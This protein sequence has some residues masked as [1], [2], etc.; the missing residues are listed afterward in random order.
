MKDTILICHSLQYHVTVKKDQYLDVVIFVSLISPTKKSPLLSF[1]SVII[2]IKNITEV[3][4]PVLLLQVI[5][6]DNIELNNGKCLRFN[7]S[8]KID[9]YKFFIF[10]NLYFLLS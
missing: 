10:I 1:P 6:K 7:L 4:K 5:Q 3:I 8:D 2:S 9:K